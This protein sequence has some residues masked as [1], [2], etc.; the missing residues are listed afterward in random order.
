M[1]NPKAFIEMLL[2]IKKRMD[3]GEDFSK[4]LKLASK[5]LSDSEMT[6]EDAYK[7]SKAAGNL[8]QWL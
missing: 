8:L 4:G 6:L 5:L 7:K 2:G 3:S 1:A